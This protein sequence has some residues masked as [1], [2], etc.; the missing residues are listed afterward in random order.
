MS[1]YLLDQ[2]FLFKSIIGLIQIFGKA[3]SYFCRLNFENIE[4]II[5]I[6]IK[7]IFKILGGQGPSTH[8]HTSAPGSLWQLPNILVMR[9]KKLINTVTRN[10]CFTIL[11]QL[12]ILWHKAEKNTKKISGRRGLIG[13]TFFRNWF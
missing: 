5:Y 9:N 1:L 8:V 11:L 12:H 2:L 4:I 6:Y 13:T 7:K 3:N 10:I